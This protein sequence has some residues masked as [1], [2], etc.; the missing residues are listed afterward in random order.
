MFCSVD[1][2]YMQLRRIE[3]IYKN[4]VLFNKLDQ[5]K[6]ALL[7]ENK[8]YKGLNEGKRCFVI[9]NGP[10]ANKVDFS[11]LEK[12]LVITVNQIFYHQDFNKLKS[13]FHFIADPAFLKLNRLN[14]VQADIINKMNR[15]SEN[16]TTLFMP[17]DGESKARHY[18]WKNEININYF[19]SELF[20]YDDYKESIDF[21]KYI[22]S[23]QS[24]VQWGIA[25][26]VYMGCKEIYL[27]GCDAT[28]IVTDLSLFLNT[29]APLDYAYTLSKEAE[30]LG[31]K[32]RRERGLEY[33]LFGYWRI[34][35][36]FAQLY[37]YCEKSKVRLYNCSEESI[38]DSIPKK[39]IEK[40]L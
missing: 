17:L 13:N 25:F 11:K 15:L 1:K 34:V 16:H 36:L 35:H 33:S 20:F 27:L 14:A 39:K 32:Q 30:N 26:A 38:L 10:S 40:V 21:T 28:N 29:D 8:K 12:E 24:V 19:M 31:R 5:R 22:P 23:F 9:G 3:N 6:K 37:Q 2:S 7:L 18:R 4:K